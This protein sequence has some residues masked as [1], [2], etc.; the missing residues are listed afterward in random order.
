MKSAKRGLEDGL[1]KIEQ[2][3][4]LIKGTGRTLGQAALQWLWSEPLLATALP[5]IYDERQLE[6]LCAAPDTPA[7]TGEEVARVKD[8]YAYNFGL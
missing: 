7:L 1:Q 6:E 8:L 4:F 5:N 2:L 3:D